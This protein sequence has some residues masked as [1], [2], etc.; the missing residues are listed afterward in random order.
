MATPLV[1][2][3]S[4]HML[5][6]EEKNYRRQQYA[7]ARGQHKEDGGSSSSM[8]PTLPEGEASAPLERG[9]VPSP[10]PLER[11]TTE[12]EAASLPLNE[13][14]QLCGGSPPPLEGGAA[15]LPPDWLP[16]GKVPSERLPD[17]SQSFRSAR[18]ESI[19]SSEDQARTRTP[20]SPPPR[21]TPRHVVACAPRYHPC[22]R[23]PCAHRSRAIACRPPNAGVDLTGLF[24]DP[25]ERRQRADVA[26][27]GRASHHGRDA[28]YGG[29]EQ[30]RCYG[31]RASALGC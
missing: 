14:G 8:L 31:G 9:M 11:R 27:Y 4:F 16:L 26:A 12:Q 17:A 18:Q 1:V 22:F 7:R 10:P 19:V 20:P 6:I 5:P 28:N 23:V 13:L 25:R 15:T 29:N 30:R 3:N 21:R 24:G 2:R